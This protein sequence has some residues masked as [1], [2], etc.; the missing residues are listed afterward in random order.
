MQSRHT[1][2]TGDKCHRSDGSSARYHGGQSAGHHP[3]ARRTLRWRC[4]WHRHQCLHR[5]VVAVA[6]AVVSLPAA[7]PCDSATVGANHQLDGIASPAV[8]FIGLA[9]S[10]ISVSSSA[11]GHST[12]DWHPADEICYR[13]AGVVTGRGTSQC[14]LVPVPR[15]RR[16]GWTTRHQ[17]PGGTSLCPSRRRPPWPWRNFFDS[18]LYCL[19]SYFWHQMWV[20]S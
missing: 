5:P 8:V 1:G 6:I 10:N 9:T 7:D 15:R 3:S 11:A 13:S 19:V 18:P 2:D 14:P 16:L 12:A 17:Y 4:I 20:E